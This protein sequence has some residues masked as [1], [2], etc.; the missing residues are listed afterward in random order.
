VDAVEQVTISILEAFLWYFASIKA[1]KHVQSNV[2]KQQ[3]SKSTQS[4]CLLLWLKIQAMIEKH[5]NLNA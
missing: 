2:Q 4:R 1:N 3:E 5:D